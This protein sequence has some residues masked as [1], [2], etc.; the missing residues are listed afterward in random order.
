MD[1]F[2]CCSILILMLFFDFLVC[3]FRWFYL[4]DIHRFVDLFSGEFLEHSWYPPAVCH[5]LRISFS[6]SQWTQHSMDLRLVLAKISNLKWEK[7]QQS[8]IKLLK[9]KYRNCLHLIY[10]NLWHFPDYNSTIRAAWNNV[11]AA[12]TE[13][14]SDNTGRMSDAGTYLDCR[15]IVP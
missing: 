7:N 5:I 11:F 6:H 8:L 1:F 4:V 14:T 12:R 9:L 3:A 2:L 13:T 10:S 15:L